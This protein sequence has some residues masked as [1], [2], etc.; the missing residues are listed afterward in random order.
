MDMSSD[1]TPDHAKVRCSPSGRPAP[2]ARWRDA[3]TAHYWLFS[4]SREEAAISGEVWSLRQRRPVSDQ[5]LLLAVVIEVSGN[6]ATVVPLSTELAQATEWD[7]IVPRYVLGYETIAQV[8]LTGSVALGQLDQRISSLPPRSQE[9]LTEL[10][11]AVASRTSIPPEHL[12]LGPW[13]LSEADPRLQARVQTAE[14][15][16]AYLC[17][18]DENPISEWQSLGSILMRGSRAVGIDLA[19]LMENSRS[20]EQLRTDRLDLFAEVPARKMAQILATL[21][22]GWTQR[23][24]DALYQVVSERYSATGFDP[25][26]VL[27]RRRDRRSRRRSRSQPSQQEREQAARDYVKALEREI[28]E[29]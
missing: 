8:K 14:L 3:T 21:R 27:G 26:I 5:E 9:Q 28:G 19:S 12:P 22:I 6:D 15:L 25:G 11:A 10:A 1:M 2:G 23:V 29:L 7:L 13:V 20:V 4:E 16:R 17:L 18:K 24:R